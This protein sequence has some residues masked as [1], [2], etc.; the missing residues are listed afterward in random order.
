MSVAS[1]D[2]SPAS[3]FDAD[4]APSAPPP[5]PVPPSELSA[6]FFML[7]VPIPATVAATTLRGR[8]RE[9]VKHDAETG[10]R[11]HSVGEITLAHTT[12]VG[13]SLHRRSPPCVVPRSRMREKAHAVA[14][15]RPYKRA[16]KVR[17][18]RTSYTCT[19]SRLKDQAST[20]T[21]GVPV[22]DGP[23]E[24]AVE[25]EQHKDAHVHTQVKVSPS[26]G[27][28][29]VLRSRCTPFFLRFLTLGA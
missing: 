3:S 25:C 23:K 17:T 11:G 15:E 6:F 22:V 21:L 2:F 10:R 26:G 5:S 13:K 18:I 9:W 28:G 19:R 12:G 27:C 7:R 8:T 1:T 24:F 20:R 29:R 14:E 16:K 4:Q